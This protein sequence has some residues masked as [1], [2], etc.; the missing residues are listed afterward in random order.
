MDIDIW[1]YP[2]NK[3]SGSVSIPNKYTE[4]IKKYPS[5]GNADTK[6]CGSGL[7]VINKFNYFTV[8]YMYMLCM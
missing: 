5:P 7:F 8:V 1:I 2:D 6:F 3:L 4:P